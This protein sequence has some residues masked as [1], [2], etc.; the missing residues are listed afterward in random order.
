MYIKLIED[1]FGDLPLAALKDPRI[2]GEFKN[3]RGKFGNTPRKTDLAWSG[4]A[5]M[6]SFSKDRGLIAC[7]PCEGGGRLYKADRNDKI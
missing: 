6:L 7:N 2:R 4:L 5:R 3:W 1:D